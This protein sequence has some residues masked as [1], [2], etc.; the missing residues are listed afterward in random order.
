[1]HTPMDS[2]NRLASSFRCT[3]SVN[4]SEVTPNVLSVIIQQTCLSVRRLY[5]HFHRWI[6]DLRS[7]RSS[8]HR[9]ISG[10]KETATKR[11]VDFLDWSSRTTDGTRHGTS[12]LRPSGAIPLWLLVMFAKPQKSRSVGP[13]HCWHFVS[14]ECLIITWCKGRIHVGAQSRR[15]GWQLSGRQIWPQRQLCSYQYLIYLYLSRISVVSHVPTH[16][17]HG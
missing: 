3:Y 6:S 17:N 14:C 5:S 4:K 1:M 10:I 12:V 7:C 2:K 16:W 11:L 9:G 13:A 8:S 15:T